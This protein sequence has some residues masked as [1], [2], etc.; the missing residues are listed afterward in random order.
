MRAQHLFLLCFISPWALVYQQNSAVVMVQAFTPLLSTS[1]HPAR[2]T[3]STTTALNVV[4]TRLS[5]DCLQALGVAQE[6]SVLSKQKEIEASYMLLGLCEHPG[7]TKPVLDK[8]QIT[9]QTVRQT[10]N[11]YAPSA[12]KKSLSL[13]DF[14]EASAD[15]QLP[16]SKYLQ[17]R[18]FDAGRISQT[19]GASEILPE[20]VFLAMLHYEEIDGET[21][22]ATRG[23]DCEVMEI[24]Y[25][26]DATLEGEDV[27]Q[28]LLQ[29]LMEAKT[30]KKDKQEDIT[31]PP[32]ARSGGG[33]GGGPSSPLSPTATGAKA[34]TNLTLLEQYGTDLTK[35]ATDGELDIVHGRED[36]IQS[37]IRI[38]LRRRKN[39]V[40][41]IGEAGT[42]KTAI[43]EALAQRFVSGENCPVQLKGYKMISLET[44]GLLAGTKFRGAFEERLKGIIDEIVTGSSSRTILFI[45]E[46]HTLMGAGSTEGSGSDAAQ[47]LKP[48]LVRSGLVWLFNSNLEDEPNP[49]HSNSFIFY[50]SIKRHEDN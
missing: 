27:C 8:Y 32:T 13:A 11:A 34:D 47:L 14:K 29:A 1:L 38:L 50:S 10:L 19:M 9:W 33:G 41:I 17:E 23:D 3:R 40:C 15:V 28:D 45:D 4:F 25:N 49:N 43:A 6:Q 12:A 20:H 21:Y 7:D 44:S 5:Q 26:M 16:Y 22:A 31:I 39:N 35:M 48:Y 42:G 36:E 30:K 46:M 37:C 24:L 2:T 18:L